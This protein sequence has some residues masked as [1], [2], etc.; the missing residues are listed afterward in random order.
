MSTPDPLTPLAAPPEAP[1]PSAR[2][3]RREAQV[4][5]AEAWLAAGLAGAVIAA[6]EVPLGLALDWWDFEDVSGVMNVAL[7]LLMLVAAARLPRLG[8]IGPVDAG[9]GRPGGLAILFALGGLACWL[10][11]TAIAL[12]LVFL[13]FTARTTLQVLGGLFVLGGFTMAALA[14]VRARPPRVGDPVAVSGNWAIGLLLLGATLELILALVIGS[15]AGPFDGLPSVVVRVPIVAGLAA[16]T[17]TAAAT[18]R[19]ALHDVD[20]SDVF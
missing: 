5:A 11:R 6:A 17:A 7:T 8:E 4:R 14:F 13:G 12:D 15:L 10:G 18:R 3:R 2:A 20:V 19:S 9:A 1:P 16:L